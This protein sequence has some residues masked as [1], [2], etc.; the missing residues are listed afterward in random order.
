M[1]CGVEGGVD[2]GLAPVLDSFLVLNGA[3]RLV[4]LSFSLDCASTGEHCK[5]CMTTGAR[6]VHDTERKYG[7]CMGL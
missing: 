2:D 5:H 7:P 1:W 4:F 6:V 3:A